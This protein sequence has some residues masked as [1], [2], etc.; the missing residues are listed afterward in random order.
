[1]LYI[2]EGRDLPLDEREVLE[3][4]V[5]GDFA[6]SRRVL[7]NIRSPVLHYLIHYVR[8]LLPLKTEP[9]NFETL[10]VAGASHCLS[11]GWESVWFKGGWY[12]TRPYY[13]LDLAIT[14]FAHRPLEVTEFLQTIVERHV[15][16]SCGGLDVYPRG[17]LCGAS[18]TA[19]YNA[20]AS[21]GRLLSKFPEK[22]FYLMGVSSGVGGP[23]TKTI[24]TALARV[25]AHYGFV[26]LPV[27]KIDAPYLD[28][29]HFHPQ[30]ISQLLAGIT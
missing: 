27:S 24:N 7:A 29:R 26:Y 23:S 30:F 20:C 25:C 14:T 3:S 5:R 10:A 1:M 2:P 18:A 22:Q 15:V 16:L 9:L 4:F 6:H 11:A 21:L 13:Y 28:N 8:T 12:T 17:A 19:C